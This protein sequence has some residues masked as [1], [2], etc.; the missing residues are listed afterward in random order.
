MSNLRNTALLAV[1][2]LGSSAVFAG[3]MGPVCTPGNVTVPCE[4]NAWTFGGQALYLQPTGNDFL[5][6]TITTGGDVFRSANPDWDWGFRLEAGYQFGTGNDLNVNWAH[7]D[8]D[9]SNRF[10]FTDADT[11]VTSRAFDR[12]NPKWDAVNVKIGQHV[13]FGDMKSI[14]FHAGAQWAKVERDYGFGLVSGRTTT[15]NVGNKFDGAG[16]RVG[17]D[18]NYGL[19]NGFG[20]YANGAMAVLVGETDFSL[21]SNTDNVANFHGSKNSVVPVLDGK[22][23]ISYTYPM[24]QGDLVLDAGYMV[25]EYLNAFSDVGFSQDFGMQGVFAGLK[26]TGNV[27]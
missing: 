2:A 13:D 18:L 1:L 23:G 14:R 16:P 6:T 24:A 26:W 22:V 20:V 15:G 27:M 5:G 3:T 12:V 11:G 10:T 19:G 17:M 8:N 9:S 21:V 4:R 7:F 25:V